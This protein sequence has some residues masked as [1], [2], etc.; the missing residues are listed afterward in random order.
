[1]EEAKREVE[2]TI[3]SLD[4]IVNHA[5]VMKEEIELLI[6]YKRLIP[7]QI[8]KTLL[9][10]TTKVIQLIRRSL[11]EAQFEAILQMSHPELE[12]AQ[13]FKQTSLVS[14][15][16]NLVFMQHKLARLNFNLKGVD[17]HLSELINKSKE[18][19]IKKMGRD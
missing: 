5:R 8:P 13:G 19:L 15:E 9:N 18:E 6:K 11:T 16:H 1:M 10:W 3:D 7:E 12:L 4:E 17:S 14:P 2:F